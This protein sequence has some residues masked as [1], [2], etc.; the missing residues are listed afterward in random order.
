MQLNLK[1]VAQK[2]NIHNFCKLQPARCIELAE[3]LIKNL[4]LNSE[5]AT[6]LKKFTE[7][8]KNPHVNNKAFYLFSI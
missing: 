6:P 1:G 8:F 4:A 3:S 5:K 2:I 7:R